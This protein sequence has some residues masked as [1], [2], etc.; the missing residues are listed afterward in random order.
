MTRRLGVMAGA[1]MRQT[2][3]INSGTESEVFDLPG[4]ANYAIIGT[5]GT[6]GRQLRLQVADPHSQGQWLN[7]PLFIVTSDTDSYLWS[8]SDLQEY[9]GLCGHQALR[10]SLSVADTIKVTFFGN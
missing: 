10:L 8:F 9:S 6:A 4:L 7:T 1:T 3:E 5:T 2:I